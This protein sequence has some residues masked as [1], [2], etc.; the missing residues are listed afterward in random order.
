MFTAS[1]VHPV[2][3]LRRGPLSTQLSF[4]VCE[5]CVVLPE[6]T[7][8]VKQRAEERGERVKSEISLC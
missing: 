8:K 5:P 2:P 4:E 7:D 1:D 6:N 3:S